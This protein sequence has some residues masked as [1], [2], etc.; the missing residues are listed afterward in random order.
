M[1]LSSV[2]FIYSLDLPDYL[3]FPVSPTAKRSTEATATLTWAPSPPNF[4]RVSLRINFANL[5][6]GNFL[7]FNS[8]I[9]GKGD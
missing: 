9:C 5:A 3:Y 6:T 8:L 1:E 2:L 7:L 4:H